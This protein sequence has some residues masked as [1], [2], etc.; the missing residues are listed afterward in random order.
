[1][2]ERITEFRELFAE[3]ADVSDSVT[4]FWMEIAEN[5]VPSAMGVLFSKAL[6]LLTAHYLVKWADNER[7]VAVGQ[8]G[9]THGAVVSK[10][11]GG[12][13]V[14]YA[15]PTGSETDVEL[16]TTSYGKRYLDLVRPFTVGCIQL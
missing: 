11:V 2:D 15:S 12:V 5:Y 9:S 1:M 6:Y 7:S 13:S 14:G 4:A 16:S 3:F 8:T 10:S